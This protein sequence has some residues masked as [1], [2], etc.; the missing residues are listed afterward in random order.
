MSLFEKKESPL[1][2]GS[3]DTESVVAEKGAGANESKSFSQEQVEELV[4]E[5]LSKAERKFA[6]KQLELENQL[7]L[8]KNPKDTDVSGGSVES[9]KKDRKSLTP[10]ELE[11][12]AKLNEYKAK[13]QALMEKVNKHRQESFRATIIQKLTENDCID[14][15]L[16]FN[17][18]KSRELIKIDEEDEIVVPAMFKDS[19]EVIKDYLAKHEYLVKAKRQGGM[20]TKGP[21]PNVETLSAKDQLLSRVRAHSTGVSWLQ[22]KS[23][24]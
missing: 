22:N 16:V 19:D 10:L 23:Q 13:E 15:E 14:S 3:A 11:Y 9:D 4:K 8:F 24:K 6:R 17:D 5:R 7:D 18:L 12:Q 20:G 21:N 2:A 1:G